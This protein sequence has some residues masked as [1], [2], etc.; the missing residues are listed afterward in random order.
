MFSEKSGNKVEFHSIPDWTR[1][2]TDFLLL[3]IK[4]F[5]HA[6]SGMTASWLGLYHKWYSGQWGH[7]CLVSKEVSL[8]CE[9]RQRG[10]IYFSA[11]AAAS[12]QVSQY[13]FARHREMKLFWRQLLILSVTLQREEPVLSW[14]FLSGWK[15]VN[16]KL[17]KRL[18][19]SWCELLKGAET[20]RRLGIW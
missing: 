8:Q 13:T 5:I 3:R 17:R 9:E 10:Q 18:E 14:S 6:L 11:T 1:E 4:Y 2:F 15:R 19:I 20:G 16:W 7:F 12:I